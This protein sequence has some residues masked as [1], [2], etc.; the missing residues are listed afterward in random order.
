MPAVT[1]VRGHRG[2][3]ETRAVTV[4]IFFFSPDFTGALG[5]V[6]SAATGDG[7]VARVEDV[8]SQSF[9]LSLSLCVS[10]QVCLSN[11]FGL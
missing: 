5:L 9:S 11:V 8:I 2:R 7:S 6:V 4:A 10:F 1:G 3:E